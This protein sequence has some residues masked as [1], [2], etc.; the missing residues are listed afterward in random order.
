MAESNA[1]VETLLIRADELMQSSQAA[2]RKGDNER[3]RDLTVEARKCIA[4][5][6]E[7]A[8]DGLAEFQKFLD[9][10]HEVRANVAE[11]LQH[12]KHCPGGEAH[13]LDDEEDE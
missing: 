1:R 9:G 6:Q 8:D 11:W 13:Q 3:A 7:L 10:I 5:A 12:V 4:E 2:H